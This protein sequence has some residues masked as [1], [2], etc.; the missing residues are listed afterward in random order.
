MIGSNKKLKYI[1]DRP[2]NDVRY[3][4]NSDKI[5]KLGWK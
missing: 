1:I 5:R 2:Y 3:Y 4:I